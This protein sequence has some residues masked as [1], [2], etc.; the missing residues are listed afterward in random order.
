MVGG[1]PLSR[2]VPCMTDGWAPTRTA[3]D[4]VAAD[5]ARLVRLDQMEATIDLAMLDDFAR[6]VRGQGR[7]LDAGCG[8]G[9]IT[10]HL[11]ARGVDAFGIDLAPGMIAVAREASGCGFLGGKHRCRG[12]RE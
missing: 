5:Y 11:L 10:D 1:H 12:R 8:P 3:Y 7:V 9:R 4:M 2:T 6:R